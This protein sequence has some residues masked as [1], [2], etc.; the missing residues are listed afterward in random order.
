MKEAIGPLAHDGKCEAS[1]WRQYLDDCAH[2]AYSEWP[3]GALLHDLSAYA[4][5]EIYLTATGEEDESEIEARIA[6]HVEAAERFLSHCPLDAWLGEK[7]A[8][9]LERTVAMARCRLALDRGIPVDPA[10]L[11]ELG[12]IS[13]S[14]MRSLISGT[15]PELKR[16]EGRIPAEIALPWLEK[17]DGFLRIYMANSSPKFRCARSR[18]RR[19]Q[20]SPN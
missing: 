3:L 2:Y 17:R 18:R 15:P 4:Q 8:P 5:Y 13:Q 7:R 1:N 11:A 16:E 19:K 6:E 12:N 20:R 9:Q 14:R 10:D